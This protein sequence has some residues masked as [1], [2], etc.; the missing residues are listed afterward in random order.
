M[1]SVEGDPLRGKGVRE[2]PVPSSAGQRG[3]KESDPPGAIREASR[4]F[5]ALAEVLVDDLGN[6]R[7]QRAPPSNGRQCLPPFG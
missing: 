7:F 2:L 3:L 1:P 4:R 6:D 5:A